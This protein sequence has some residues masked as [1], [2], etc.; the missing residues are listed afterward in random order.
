MT[1][2]EKIR[3]IRTKRGLTQADLGGDLVTPSMISQIEADRTK[4]SYPLLTEIANR[5]GMPVEYFM[6]EM[7]EQF[8]FSAQMG[9][10]MYQMETQNP[11]AALRQL[12]SM[13]NVPEQGLSHQEYILTLAQ[14]YRKLRRYSEAIAKLEHLREIAYRTQDQRL[15]LHVCRETGYVEADLAN[16][17][18]ALYEWTHAMEIGLSLQQSDAMSDLDLTVLLTDILLELDKVTQ[19]DKSFANPNRPYLRQAYAFITSTPDLRA[20]SD[21]LIESAKECLN[22]DAA[23]AKSLAEKANT[24]LAFAHMVEHSIIVQTRMIEIG[25]ASIGD[26]WQQAAL[27]MT[28][29]YPDLFL[30]TECDQIERLLREGRI[31]LAQTKMAHANSMLNVLRKQHDDQTLQ[32]ISLR[33][34]LLDAQ[35]LAANG[36]RDD[37][38]AQLDKFVEAF[39]DG[40]STELL[41]KACAL[42]VLWYGETAATEKVLYYCRKMEQLMVEHEREA[43]LPF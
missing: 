37:A 33:L 38:I 1:I 32:K 36:R 26:P 19:A 4:P 13:Q 30:T 39:P 25:D 15:L 24:L 42:L 27:A 5:L 31:A 7:D 16:T 14:T 34:A 35:T 3:D 8:L 9:V 20:I 41:V 2:G 23:K 10:A 18:G 17:E 40:A 22:T 12:E 43:S 11:E 6:N 28:S 29:I 21:K